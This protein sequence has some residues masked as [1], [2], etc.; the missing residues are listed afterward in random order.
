MLGADEVQLSLWATDG[1]L[2]DLTV[3]LDLDETVARGRLDAAQGQP[4]RPRGREGCLPRARAEAFLGLAAAEPE[5]F[6]VVDA[7]LP[8]QE[9][10][11]LIRSRVATLLG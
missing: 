9:I 8:V 1:L 7:A 10:A 11:A 6:L 4:D 3:L 5:R 2:P